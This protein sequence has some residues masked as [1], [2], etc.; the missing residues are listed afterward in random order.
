MKPD[1][2]LRSFLSGVPLFGG[3]SDATT[4]RLIGMLAEQK[5]VSGAT[6]CR[7]GE[8]G[9]CMYLVREGE[10]MVCREMPAG[11]RIR[12][13][14]LGRGEFFGEMALF[15]VQA[16]SATVVADQP[17][18]V[19]S[20]T[21]GD[22]YR[23]YREDIEGYVMFLQNI[24]RELSRRL[25]KADLRISELAEEAGSTTTQIGRSSGRR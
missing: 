17:T 9:R 13:V 22:L 10:V 1:P 2:R 24:C 20:L 19:Y 25:R 7:Q 11:K 21:S 15:D 6:V 16:R 5:L 4:D 3:L 12:M 14:R 8:P 18:T 23:L